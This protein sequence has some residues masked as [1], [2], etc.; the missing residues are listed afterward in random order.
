MLDALRHGERRYLLRQ[1]PR[2]HFGLNDLQGDSLA[3]RA[4]ALRLL[5]L[6]ADCEASTAELLLGM[7][8][9]PSRIVHYLRW[10][11][12]MGPHLEAIASTF[13]AA[14][15]SRRNGG[16]FDFIGPHVKCFVEPVF[17]FVGVELFQV[18]R[19]PYGTFWSLEPFEILWDLLR[20]GVAGTAWR[21][22]ALGK[23]VL[24]CH[25]DVLTGRVTFACLAS[26]ANH[27]RKHDSLLEKE[28]D[29]G[30]QKRGG[31]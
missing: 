2:F 5:C 23:Q 1:L 11:V 13:I 22:D 27:A 30:V 15:N 25:G 10:S 12:G 19:N 9:P 18:P 4:G 7:V 6:P 17:S 31:T 21:I 14:S 16:V 3:G 26:V 24:G 29:G 20:L 8:L 28:V